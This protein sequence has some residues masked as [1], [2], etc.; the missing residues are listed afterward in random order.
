M[1]Y[2]HG[3]RFQRGRGLGSIFASLAR[4]IA[5][6]TRLGLKA[7]RSLISSPLVKQIGKTNLQKKR[8]PKPD[9]EEVSFMGVCSLFQISN[10]AKILTYHFSLKHFHHYIKL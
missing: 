5:P 9:F 2:H 7:G 3:P 6:I 8:I 1:N 10:S 4:G